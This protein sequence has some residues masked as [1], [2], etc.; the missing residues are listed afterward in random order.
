LDC[1]S[2]DDGESYIATVP[3]VRCES[4]EYASYFAL[5][6]VCIVLVVA[7]IP[8][9]MFALMYMYRARL[10]EPK[11]LQRFG[12]LFLR[13]LT[14]LFPLFHPFLVFLFLFVWFCFPGSLYECY[15]EKYFYFEVVILLRRLAIVAVFVYLRSDSSLRYSVLSLVN[16]FYL[17]LHTTCQP[18]KDPTDNKKVCVADYSFSFFYSSFFI[19]SS[20]SVVLYFSSP[21]FSLVCRP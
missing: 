11:I 4:P 1:V 10:N 14:V 6:M 18:Y 19:P 21:D 17:A 7:G 2:L 20:A 5:F 15:S 13:L 12:R 3:S 16:V 9:T 8:V